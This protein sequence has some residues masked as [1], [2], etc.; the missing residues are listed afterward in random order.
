M[1]GR[2]PFFSAPT[3]EDE[4]EQPAA[5]SEAQKQPASKANKVLADGTYA[6][7]SAY[8]EDSA[9]TKQNAKKTAGP[10]LRSEILAGKFDVGAVA[11]K[12]LG[13][14]AL[15][16]QASNA[17]ERIKNG[18]TAEVLYICACFLQYIEH[19][20]LYKDSVS[21]S[22]SHE[23]V[24]QLIRIILEP[25]EQLYSTIVRE[26]REAHKRHLEEYNRTMNVQPEKKVVDVQVDD[27]LSIRLLQGSKYG[28]VS[29]ED[30]VE[31]DL[32]KATGMSERDTEAGALSRVHQLTGFSDPLYAECYIN[33]HRYDIVLEVLVINRTKDTLQNVGL[34]LSTVGDL[35]ITKRAQLQTHTLAPLG[36]VWIRSDVKVSSTETGMIYGNL[37][38][39]IAG[40]AVSDKHCVVL[41]NIRVDILDYIEPATCSDSQYRNMWYEFEWEN[42]VPVSAKAASVFEFLEDIIRAT[43]MKCLTPKSAM[44]GDCRF[45]AANLYARS[46]FG[47][48]ALANMSVEQLENGEISGYIRIRSKTQGIALSL[49]DKI[50]KR[51]Q[52]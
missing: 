1:G 48:D 32:M 13:K 7:Q 50:A 25:N 42:K 12:T 19:S 28:H 3:E 27:K 14:V 45:L 31:V 35:Q 22:T 36:K 41:N 52:P 49:G 30:N 24:V 51:A 39:D 33:A 40:S 2:M 4:E 6:T 43:N 18:V 21:S 8:V 26:S 16:L 34:E 46:I 17:D 47:E 9:S 10:F 23:E 44:E 15:K 38:Y 11:M 29:F 37:V 20:E 5:V